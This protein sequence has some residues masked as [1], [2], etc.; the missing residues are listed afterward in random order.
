MAAA[1]YEIRLPKEQRS[2]MP[3]RL[4]KEVAGSREIPDRATQPQHRFRHLH[5]V[6]V[7]PGLF[8]ISD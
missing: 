1:P 4:E 5:F 8:G 6:Y 3:Q 7:R 2:L